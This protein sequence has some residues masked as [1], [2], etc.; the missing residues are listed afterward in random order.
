M[1]K[2]VCLS[3]LMLEN[4]EELNPT[5][6]KMKKAKIDLIALF[7]EE[8]KVGFWYKNIKKSLN[9]IYLESGNKDSFECYGFSD[10]GKW[11]GLM[12]RSAFNCGH[13]TKATHQEIETALINE[14]KKRGFEKGVKYLS[15]WRGK[16]CTY[17]EN[18]NYD[19]ERNCLSGRFGN[20]CI[21]QNGTWATIIKPKQM[22]QE[23]IEK[24]LGY[25]IEIV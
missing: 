11:M 23:E 20:N 24:E 12:N 8:L 14:A 21:F 4:L 16:N 3:H 15:A 22:T 13:Y 7:E 5:T 6:E 1:H 9:V 19:S 17:P 2:L 18:L 10:S 25:K